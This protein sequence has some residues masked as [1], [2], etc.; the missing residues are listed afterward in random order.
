M[1]G[2]G[3]MVVQTGPPPQGCE[4]CPFHVRT[5][6][7]AWVP[8]PE[9]CGAF[10]FPGG[11]TLPNQQLL[12][13][14][15][16][17]P[18]G[19]LLQSG[20]ASNCPLH[21][22][23]PE[24]LL[25]DTHGY[26]HSVLSAY[27]NVGYI[28]LY[29]NYTPSEE[30][31]LG[32]GSV[33]A[34]T[35]FLEEWPGARLDLHFS[36]LYHT[37]DGH[38]HGPANRLALRALASLWPRVTLSPLCAGGW[39]SLLRGFVRGVPAEVWQRPLLPGRVAADRHNAYQIAAITGVAPAFLDLSL[40]A[41]AMP[42]SRPPHRPAPPPP[43]PLPLLPPA[44]IPTPYPSLYP[45]PNPPK[46][47]SRN[48]V[49]HVRMPLPSPGTGSSLRLPPGQAVEM[50]VVREREEEED[51]EEEEGSMRDRRHRKGRSHRK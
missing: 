13:Y 18:Q 10:G 16:R 28:C 50:V 42:L 44:L 14:E 48:V 33:S 19:A 21:R 1:A 23:E 17:T 5:G 43:P 4:R 41:P 26:L 20:Q 51:K 2:W 47:R 29:S 31:G 36:Q 15:L 34:M 9:F 39:L 24:R 6:E 11:P 12:F 8:Y 32:G 37:Q 46:T 25:F 38:P 30:P 45:Y 3:Q 35:R 27:E 22:L 40:E 49:R 7:D